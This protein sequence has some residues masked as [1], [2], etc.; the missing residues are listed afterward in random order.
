MQVRAL[1]AVASLAAAVA[2]VPLWWPTVATA[3]SY[4]VQPGESLGVIASRAG[5]SSA[6]LAALNG[7][8]DPN[9]IYPGQILTTS[10]P[11][12]YVVRSGDTL[13]AIASREGVSVSYLTALNGLANPNQIYAGQSLVTSGPLPLAKTV[14]MDIQ[15]PVDGDV[16]FVNDFGYIRA[17][18]TPHNGIDLFADRGTPVVA[19]VSGLMARYPNPSGGNA[20]EFYGDDGIRYYGAHLDSYGRTGYVAA[21]SVIGYVG[22]TGDASTTSPHLHF[23]MHPGDELTMSPYPTLYRA[24]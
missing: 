5:M 11:T 9:L 21:G 14:T 17:D 23:E 6:R 2:V 22:N 4:T 7:I 13:S 15:C 10:E 20:F 19:P 24:C 3:D 18:G 1:A 12:K 16:S 8:G